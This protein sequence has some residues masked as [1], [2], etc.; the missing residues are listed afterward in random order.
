MPASSTKSTA[1]PAQEGREGP[2]DDGL[3]V[4]IRACPELSNELDPP[5]LAP[6]SRLN[7]SRTSRCSPHRHLRLPPSHGDDEVAFCLFVRVKRG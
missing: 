3:G 4:G 6:D 5:R 7:P 2:A 1:H